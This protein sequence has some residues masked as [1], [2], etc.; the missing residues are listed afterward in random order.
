MANDTRLDASDA[1]AQ[2]ALAR[3]EALGYFAASC[4][5]ALRFPDLPLSGWLNDD[6]GEAES[7]A[8]SADFWVATAERLERE[9]STETMPVAAS[10]LP[11]LRTALAE[12]RERLE[13]LRNGTIPAL[14]GKEKAARHAER[15]REIVLAYRNRLVAAGVDASWVDIEGAGGGYDDEENDEEAES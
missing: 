15:R 8:K 4:P 5:E 12:A 14:T 10:D 13:G 1:M 11:R 2:D 3:A 9:G 6:M 7:A